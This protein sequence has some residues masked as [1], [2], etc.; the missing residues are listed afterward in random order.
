MDRTILVVEDEPTVLMFLEEALAEGGYGVVSARS[1]GEALNILGDGLSDFSLLVAD[2]RIG[3]GLDGWE[4][5]RCARE[6]IPDLPIV[7]VTGDSA[8]SWS[9]EGVPN[10]LLLQ[11]PFDRSQLEGAIETLLSRSESPAGG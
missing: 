1:G 3:D 8:L 7:Y 11:K 5:A 6:I 10:S 2:I 9:E 4:I